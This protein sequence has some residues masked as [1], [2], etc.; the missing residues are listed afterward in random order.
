MSKQRNLK[1]VIGA[2]NTQFPGWVS[3]NIDILNLLNYEDW[4]FKLK[5]NL[6]DSILA[7]H[8]WEH[9]TLEEAKTAAKVCF[10]NLKSGGNL[11]VAVPDGFFPDINYIE[12]VKPG[13]HGDGSDDHKVLFTYRTLCEV[14]I[15]AGF[16]VKLLEYFDEFGQFHELP[17]TS[18]LGPISRSKYNDARN[19]NGKLNYTS[20]I[21]DAQKS[22]SI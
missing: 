7:E 5:G 9:L 4:N 22:S 11:R 15:Q 12:A 13:G 17:F 20:I 10:A 16:K 3:T 19:L 6:I 8:V 14:F 2:G 1:I 18:E 21:L